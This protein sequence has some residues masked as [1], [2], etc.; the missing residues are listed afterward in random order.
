MFG[1]S[2]LVVVLGRRLLVRFRRGFGRRGGDDGIVAVLVGDMGVVERNAEWDEHELNEEE[3]E[4]GKG[5]EEEM[6]SRVFEIGRRDVSSAGDRGGR[7]RKKRDDGSS[8]PL[9]FAICSA[10]R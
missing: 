10:V 7:K 9:E 4:R 5:K 6:R 1:E 2:E 8:E 3:G